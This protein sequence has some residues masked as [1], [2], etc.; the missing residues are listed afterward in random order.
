MDRW[1]ELP[2]ITLYGDNNKFQTQI[3]T[4]T[5]EEE[6]EKASKQ[7]TALPLPLI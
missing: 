5:T 2:R 6:E 3:R 4:H 7:A 1:T